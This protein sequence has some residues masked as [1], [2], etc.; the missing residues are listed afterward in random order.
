MQQSLSE[1]ADKKNI[2][3]IYLM[4]FRSAIE[5]IKNHMWCHGYLGDFID[6]HDTYHPFCRHVPL[7]ETLFSSQNTSFIKIERDWNGKLTP[8]F[9]EESPSEQNRISV[10]RVIQKALSTLAKH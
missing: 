5:R 9:M 6:R 10:V 2:G 7:Y 8:I 3:G 1:I 4:T